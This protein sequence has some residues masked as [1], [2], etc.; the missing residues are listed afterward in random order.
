V[1]VGY[2]DQGVNERTNL[3]VLKKTYMPAVLVEVGFI[4]TD[5]DN[6]LFDSKFNETA[7]AIADGIIQTVKS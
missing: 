6:A 7:R 4:N 1:K 5:A 3:V 2:E